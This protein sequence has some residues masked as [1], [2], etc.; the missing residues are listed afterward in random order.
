MA[1]KTWQDGA[2]VLVPG[3]RKGEYLTGR[4]LSS[5]PAIASDDDHSALLDWQWVTCEV[6]VTSPLTSQTIRQTAKPVKS[7]ALR[8]WFPDAAARQRWTAKEATK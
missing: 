2:F 4:V 7:T 6:E 5:I 1:T 8:P 3:L